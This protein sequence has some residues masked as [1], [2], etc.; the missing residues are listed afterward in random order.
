MIHT[1]I[2]K[3]NRAHCQQQQ[4]QQKL[5]EATNEQQTKSMYAI[6]VEQLR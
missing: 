1:G 4:Q 6:R 3:I 2:N 5:F